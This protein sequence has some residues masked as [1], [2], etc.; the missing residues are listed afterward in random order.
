MQIRY[1]PEGGGKPRIVH[2]LN[3]SGLALPRIVGSLLENN[4][5]A[6]GSITIPEALQPYTGFDR[7]G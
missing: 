4:Q 1:R 7:I 3:G 6:N 5:Q 2:T